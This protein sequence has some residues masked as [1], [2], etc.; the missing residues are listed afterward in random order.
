[1]GQVEWYRNTT[2]D[3]DTSELFETKLKRARGPFNKAQYLRIQASYLLDSANSEF[4]NVGLQLMRR[5]I[6]EFPTEDFSTIFGKEQLGDYFYKTGQ[7]EEAE[8]FYRQ[9][10][11][12]YKRKSRSGT[13][14]V[15]DVKL[16]ETILELDK[17][18][19]FEEAYKL[20]T[21]DFEAT[22]GS[23][24]LNDDR[25]FYTRVA[26]EL[27]D[28]LDKKEEAKRLAGLALEIAKITEPQFTRHKTVGLVRTTNDILDR[29]RKI[30]AG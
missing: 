18:D 9:V 6:E 14:G 28:Q 3:K 13:S 1:M 12:H 17:R 27:C 11:D 16:A 19:K 26:A 15:A 2:W 24:S 4:Q 8:H 22:G 21:V 25:F 5:L 30:S 10:T 29:L 7:F 23:L 20:L